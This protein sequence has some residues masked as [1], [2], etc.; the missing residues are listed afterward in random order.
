MNKPNEI[1]P[2]TDAREIELRDLK[3]T[4]WE[5]KVGD[6]GHF[7]FNG[8]AYP[9]TV[10][11]VSASGKTVWVSRDSY[12]VVGGNFR[13]EGHKPCV[14]TPQDSSP[15]TWSKFTKKKDGFFRDG[16]IRGGRALLP[17]RAFAQ[18]PHF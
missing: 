8:D 5:P 15:E 9:V 16:P 4:E 6:G 14:F 3:A 12:R 13:E 1:N 18:N 10:R 2:E 17:G 11:K 7:G